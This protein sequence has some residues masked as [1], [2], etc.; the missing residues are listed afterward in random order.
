MGD[1]NGSSTK[2][3]F[4]GVNFAV[5]GATALDKQFFDEKG[6]HIPNTNIS[7]EF[8]LGWFK[9]L[10]HSRCKTSSG[11]ISFIIKIGI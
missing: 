3:I 11:N 10:L 7:L 4:E 9:Q 6:I 8:Q 5:A 2:N 1:K